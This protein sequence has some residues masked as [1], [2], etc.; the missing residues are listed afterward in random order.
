MTSL[1]KIED[2]RVRAFATDVIGQLPF[3]P[4]EDQLNFVIALTQFLMFSSE[5]SLMLLSGY[6]GTGKTSLTGAIVKALAQ[7]GIKCVLLAPTGRAAHVFGEYSGHAA[8][9]IH[10]KIYRQQGYGSTAFTLAEN[11]HTR[12]LFIVDEASMI[13]NTLGDSVASFGSGRLLEDLLAYVYNGKGCRLLMMGDDAQ[14]PPVGQ[15]ESPALNDGYLQALGFTV[16]HKYLRE[17]A[18]QS[19]ESGILCNATIVRQSME[20][21]MASEPALQLDGMDDIQPLSSEFLLETISDCYDR[22]GMNE[23]IV[24]TRSN[25]RANL[26]NQGIRNTILYREDLLVSGDLLLVSKNNYYWS[27]EYEEI[28][29]IANG[30]VARVV[31]VWGE[32]ESIYGLQFANVTL[33]FPDHGDIEVDAKIVLDC[34]MSDAPALIRVQSEQLYNE[35]MSE[36]PGDKR[37]KYRELKKHPYFNALQVK[38]AYAVTCHK[39]QGGQWAN[40]LI[41]MGGI[42]PEAK[43]TIDYHRWLYTAITRARQRVYLINYQPEENR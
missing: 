26:F 8:F 10:R 21:G 20:E 11:K 35:V 24:I 43:L 4:N 23:T 16:Y 41:D 29:F 5:Q 3:V 15:V 9:T 42:M 31:R 13:S 40:V 25:K 7:A 36:L 34:L 22:D 2:A 12:T 18:R 19:L 32:T 39:A 37:S 33:A 28:D 30:D 14:L 38:F 6:A 17:V 27:E 1:D